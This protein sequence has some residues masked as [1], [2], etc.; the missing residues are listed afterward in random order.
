[1][2][3]SATLAHDVVS[4]IIDREVV[5]WLAPE[6]VISTTP[7]ALTKRAA[8]SDNRSVV[9]VTLRETMCPL[10]LHNIVVVKSSFPWAFDKCLAH[11]QQIS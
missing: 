2:F 11:I 1:M 10:P 7:P 6:Y 5:A 4:I 9:F 3:E 8:Y